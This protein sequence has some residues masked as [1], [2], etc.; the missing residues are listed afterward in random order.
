MCTPPIAVPL[1][2]LQTLRCTHST[3]HTHV[4]GQKHGDGWSSRN[5]AAYPPA[6]NR[7]LARAVKSCFPQGSASTPQH[8][9]THPISD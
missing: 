1:N 6:L 7:E 9:A 5:S 3:H 8:A 2:N 4:G